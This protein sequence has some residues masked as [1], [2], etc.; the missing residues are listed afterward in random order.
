MAASDDLASD[1]AER[2]ISD[3]R[4]EMR[5]AGLLPD[6]PD[7]LEPTQASADAMLARVLGQNL[8]SQGFPPDGFERLNH[9]ETSQND[10]FFDNGGILAA[11]IVDPEFPVIELVETTQQFDDDAIDEPRVRRNKT[12]QGVFALAASIAMLAA[13]VLP[14]AWQIFNSQPTT[15]MAAETLA[16]EPI[17]PRGRI[18]PLANALPPSGTRFDSAAQLPLEPGAFVIGDIP[19]D[20]ARELG[21]STDLSAVVAWAPAEG[22]LY[23]VAWG[24][25]SC[26][27]YAAPNAEFA[28]LGARPLAIDVAEPDEWFIDNSDENFVCFDDWAP[29]TTVVSVP[30]AVDNGQPLAVAIGTL[31]QITVEPRQGPG[32]IGP[33]A[34]LPR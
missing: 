17:L 26:P 30:A 23:L 34:I 9:P 5:A 7:S 8:K 4:A 16:D 12:W 33:V 18:A 28:P 15:V 31:G 2:E 3:L 13:I 20:L 27:V 6:L 32:E 14:N 29:T 1:A 10:K 21:T 24:S 19:A 22:F 11:G 25:S